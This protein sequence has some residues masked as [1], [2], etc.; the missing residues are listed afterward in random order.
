MD[1][2]GN[3]ECYFVPDSRFGSYCSRI[4][5]PF[6]WFLWAMSQW[7]MLCYF[8]MQQSTDRRQMHGFQ[9]ARFINQQSTSDLAKISM[10]WGHIGTFYQY[11]GCAPCAFHNFYPSSPVATRGAPQ[12]IYSTKASTG[13]L[14]RCRGQIGPW[15]WAVN[16]SNRSNHGT[17]IQYLILEITSCGEI[18]GGLCMFMS[19]LALSH[20]QCKGFTDNRG[21]PPVVMALRV[22]QVRINKMGISIDSLR[23]PQE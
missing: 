2:V 17:F 9:R 22:S 19:H 6:N 14:M 20:N 12:G 13:K 4:Q 7:Q 16:R 10:W 5:G 11:F 1:G 18:C 15:W 21:V 3:T 8:Y 23:V